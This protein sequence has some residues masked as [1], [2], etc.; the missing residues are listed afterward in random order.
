MKSGKRIKRA[1]LCV[2]AAG[3]AVLSGCAVGDPVVTPTENPS[4]SATAVQE[5][6]RPNV[7]DET[8]MYVQ[9]PDVTDF[10]YMWLPKGNLGIYQDTYMMSGNYGL[11]VNSASGKI[12]RFGAFSSGMD[13][14]AAMLEDN[15]MITNLPAVDMKYSMRYQGE[16]YAFDQVQS[17]EETGASTRMLESGRYLQRLDVMCL[18]TKEK[19][20]WYGRMEVMVLPEYFTVAFEVFPQAQTCRDT[21]LQFTFELDA[22]YVSFEESLGG[23]AITVTDAAGKGFT[24]VAPQDVSVERNG[25]ALVFT[26]KALTLSRARFNGFNIAVIPSA[27]AVP[28]DAERYVAREQVQVSAERLSPKAG[29][30]QK[31][32]YDERGLYSFDLKYMFTVQE[33]GYTEDDLDTYDRVKFTIDNPTQHTIKVP[34][35]FIKDSPLSVTGVSPMIRDASTLEPI[36]VQVQ[37]TRCWH[38]YNGDPNDSSHTYAPKDSPRRYWE[39]RWYHGYTVI[40]VPAGESVTYEYTCAF[41]R[42]GGVE[43]VTH[44]QLC[45]AGWGGNQQWESASLGSYGESFCYDISR[46]WTWCVMGDIC[47]FGLYSRVNGEKYNWTTNTGGVDFLLAYDTFGKAITYRNF[48]TFFKKQGPNITEVLYSGMLGDGLVRIE[49]SAQMGRTNDVSRATQ[50]FRYTFLEDVPY[51]RMAFYQ[52]GAD[53]Y[54]YDY[55]S[56]MAVG[57]DDGLV[58]FTI[59]GNTYQGLMDVP[60]SDWNG[61]LG[62]QGMDMNCVEVPGSGAWFAFLGAAAGESKG[63]KMISVREYKAEINGEIYTQPCF[64]VRTT[65]V[66]DWKGAGF[67]LNPPKEAG[68]KIK[69]GSMVS[70]VV[71]YINLPAHKQDYYGTSSVLGE[72]SAQDYEG[73]QL[74]YTYAVQSNVSVQAS[75]GEAVG[76]LPP[77]IRANGALD[78]VT[79]QF[80]ITKGIGYVPVTVKNVKGFSGWRLQKKEGS[81]WKTVDQS[82]HGNDYWQ[83][84]YDAESGTYELTFN[85][86]QNGKDDMGEYRLIKEKA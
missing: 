52:F 51:S 67:E 50:T 54:N 9:Q 76:N 48:K 30:V 60:K 72:I 66:L 78:G 36:G 14:G 83:A 24:A 10:T 58:P 65:K 70:F 40:E 75:V 23:R 25:S 18:K 73:W 26:A 12:T 32:S 8:G 15:N 61:Y 74:A 27:A 16:S 49:V 86:H 46:S 20:D 28:A 22:S 69:A 56:T 43:S 17:L 29:E 4:A 84:W 39:G 1:I 35:Q 63:N 64:S 80:T 38:F 6:Q 2:V 68:N 77:V 85:V 57:N 13:Y 42:W 79:A 59:A 19:P 45:L 41:A 71:E 62:G 55:W 81:D 21:E 3:M 44:S 33:G 5:T 53:S 82:V 31:V 7:E 47:P 11:S 34:L 37:V